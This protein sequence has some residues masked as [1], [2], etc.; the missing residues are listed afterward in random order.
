MRT[1]LISC[2][3]ALLV[4]VACGAT[5]ADSPKVALDAKDMPIQQAMEQVGK[6]AGVQIV[7]ESS[8]KGTVNGSFESVELEKLLDTITRLNNLKW[9]KLYLPAQSDQKPTP[10]QINARAEAIAAVTGGPMVVCDPATGKQKVFVEQDSAAPSV[11]PDKLGLKLVYLI[12]KPKEEPKVE[13]KESEKGKGESTDFQSLEQ[14][15]VKLMAKM[16]PEQRVAAMQQ[17]TAYVMQLDPATR[18]QVL[19]DQFMAQRNMDPQTRDLYRQAMRD[20][21]QKMRDQGLIPP[22]GRGWGGGGGP[23]GPGG[24]GQ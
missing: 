19:I 9:Q 13:T 14:E 24:G 15:R 21:W 18:Q 11:A 5:A 8:V 10:E 12:S 20:A 2:A 1:G 16:T 6:E 17:E 7:C 4:L 23:G 3:L 22:G